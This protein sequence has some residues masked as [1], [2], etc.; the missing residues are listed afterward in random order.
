[1]K[2][3]INV[4]IIVTPSG[5][6]LAVLPEAEL[7]GLIARAAEAAAAEGVVGDAFTEALASEMEAAVPSGF[8]DR[9]LDGANPIR[10][11][12]EYR[13]LSI[14]D[15]AEATGVPAPRLALLETATQAGN[16]GEIR[17]IAMALKLSVE[18]LV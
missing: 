4:Q 18:D 13:G 12:R 6:R 5:E 2:S 17:A 16:P 14:V 9:L 10:V 1:M 7:D 11:W 15:L 8:L 3:G